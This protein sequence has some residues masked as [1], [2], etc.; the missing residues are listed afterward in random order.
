MSPLFSSCFLLFVLC[1]ASSSAV[2]ATPSPVDIGVILDLDSP[3]GQICRVSINMALVDF[4]AVYP[5]STTKLRPHFR[6]SQPDVV[7]AASDG[8]SLS[9]PLFP[10]TSVPLT[11]IIL[12]I[13]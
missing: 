7:T 10:P 5:N 4:Y 8:T 6:I 9:L 2:V 1:S 13:D 11:H 3:M 12:I